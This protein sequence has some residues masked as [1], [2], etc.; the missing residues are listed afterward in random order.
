MCPA[1]LAADHRWSLPSRLAPVLPIEAMQATDWLLEL[2]RFSELGPVQK[3]ALVAGRIRQSVPCCSDGYRRETEAHKAAAYDVDR[4]VRSCPQ[5]GVRG[6][7]WAPF[8]F[9]FQAARY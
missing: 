5:A 8:W 3:E 2:A 6:E 9:H 7:H 1:T 4:L